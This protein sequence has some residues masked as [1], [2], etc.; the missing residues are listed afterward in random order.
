MD[1]SFSYATHYKRHLGWADIQL[2][3][4]GHLSL[5]DGTDTHELQGI[6]LNA[7]YRGTRTLTHFG[8]KITE[9]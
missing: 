3:S 2:N 7:L 9:P 6:F 1:V 8:N 4:D 5:K